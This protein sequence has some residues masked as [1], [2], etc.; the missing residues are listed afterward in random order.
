MSG[1]KALQIL[2][3]AGRVGRSKVSLSLAASTPSR[4]HTQFRASLGEVEIVAIFPVL[5]LAMERELGMAQTTDRW[6]IRSTA[7][8]WG[9]GR[10]YWENLPCS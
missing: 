1:G 10:L 5:Y 6:E 4:V 7:N 8:T 3:S 2:T 9:R